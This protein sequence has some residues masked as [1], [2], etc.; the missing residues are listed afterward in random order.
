MNEPRD[1]D[2][3]ASRLHAFL[4]DCALRAYD[5]QRDDPQ[6]FTKPK[7]ECRPVIVRGQQIHPV[8]KAPTHKEH[9]LSTPLEV[10][11]LA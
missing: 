3:Q 5:D 8:N 4:D 1:D 2:G 6:L 9:L 7:D 11:S 10:A